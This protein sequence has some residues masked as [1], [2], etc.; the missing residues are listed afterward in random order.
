MTK[1][2]AVAAEQQAPVGGEP[3]ARQWRHK[4]RGTLY[5]EVGIAFLQTSG[6]QPLADGMAMMVYRDDGGT[7]WTRQFDE[8][9]DGRFQ[10][11]LPA[12]P[13]AQPA[14]IEPAGEAKFLVRYRPTGE[15]WRRPGLGLS[16][17]VAD[18]HPYTR[19]QVVGI[20]GDD[21]P[22]DCE[23][24]APSA[25]PP[26]AAPDTEAGADESGTKKSKRG[27]CS[28]QGGDCSGN[29]IYPYCRYP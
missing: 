29:C 11:V 15:Y 6:A 21:P 28:E 18:A 8:F 19:E 2:K 25:A 26:A 3:V 24:L 13:P 22:P 7:L 12:S 20:T 5:T 27:T 23:Y 14:S 1:E 10:G 16:P 9:H 4:K 17:D